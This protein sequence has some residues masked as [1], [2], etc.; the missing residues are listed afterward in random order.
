MTPDAAMGDIIGDLS[1]RRGQ[2]H[3]TRTGGDNVVVVAGQVPLAELDDY[4][5]R[6]NSIAGGHATYSIQLSHYDPVSPTQQERMAL[7]HKALGDSAGQ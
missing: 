5:S 6:L 3:G 7:Q 2:V 4:Q 1:A